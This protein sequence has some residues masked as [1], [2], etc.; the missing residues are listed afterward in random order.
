VTEPAKKLMHKAAALLAR[1]CYSRGELRDKLSAAGGP[2]EVEPLL[3]HLEQ[4]NLLNDADYAYNSASRWIKQEGWGPVKVLH[5]LLQRKV[6]GL[7]AESAL[8]RVHQEISDAGALDAYLDR[9]YRAHELPGNRK[10]IH[11][12]I[13]SLRRRGFPQD[14]IWNV[15][16][17]RIPSSAWQEFDTG[18]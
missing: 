2:E 17:Q 4:L 5:R 13:Q 16:H 15:L 14:V 11:K 12:L 10:G 9:R 3:D 18:D 8:E 1:R 6:P 7:I